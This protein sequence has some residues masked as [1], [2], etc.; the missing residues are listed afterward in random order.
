MSNILLKTLR[1][2]MRS[3]KI[4][5]KLA[6]ALMLGIILALTAAFAAVAVTGVGTVRAD[7][8]ATVYYYGLQLIEWV[9]IAL[10]FC[11]IGLFVWMRHLYLFAAFIILLIVELVVHYFLVAPA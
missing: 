4:S 11:M 3:I 7:D 1:L 6:S 8:A 5:P 2:T 10:M 9:I